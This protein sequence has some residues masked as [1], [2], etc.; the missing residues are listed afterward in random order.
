MLFRN[1]KPELVEMKC[2][3]LLKSSCFVVQ[4]FTANICKKNFLITSI[5]QKNKKETNLSAFERKKELYQKLPLI[6][7]RQKLLPTRKEYTCEEI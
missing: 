3:R 6:L 5:K 1:W 7:E 4:N 2:S